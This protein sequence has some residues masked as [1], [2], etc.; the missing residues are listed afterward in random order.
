M[1]KNQKLPEQSI[2]LPVMPHM[3]EVCLPQWFERGFQ[4]FDLNRVSRL[5]VSVLGSRG[6]GGGGGSIQ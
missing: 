6:S 4:C 2:A 1:H 5:D 3:E